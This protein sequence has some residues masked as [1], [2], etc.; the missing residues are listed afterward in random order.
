MILF[1]LLLMPFV[2]GAVAYLITKT[3]ITWKEYVLMTVVSGGVAFGG[4]QLAKWGAMRDTEHWNGRITKKDH[5]TESCC[6]CQTV[7]DAHDSD[8]NCTSSHTEC[9]HFQDYW[10]SAH[11]NTG[12]TLND[13][14]NG[15][16]TTPEWWE[17]A[18]VGEPAAIEHGY[19]NYL[20][21]D[22]D[23]LMTPAAEQYIDQVPNRP[24]VTGRYH[25][26]RVIAHQSSS[27]G[28]PTTWQKELDEMNADLGNK[29]QVDV[30]LLVTKVRDPTFAEAVKAKWLY[31]PKNAVTVV[32]GVPDGQTIEWA[33]VVTLSNVEVLKIEL[34]DE[35]PGRSLDDPEILPFIRKEI[36][37][38]YT[39]TPM[40]EYEYLAS[41]VKPPFWMTVGLYFG[42]LIIIIGLAF[43]MHREDVFGDEGRQSGRGLFRR[44]RRW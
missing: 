37:T 29:Y 7:C 40:A 27:V 3:T 28:V 36:E 30:L 11:V 39:R 20:K 24:K 41:A 2:V 33:R 12:D 17:K 19:T 8:G 42:N 35:L 9:D 1:G 31:G 32:L 14:C 44:R 22:P 15:W 34:R 10:W 16:N 43:W 4:Y 26:R 5:G 25:V 6:H 18:Y 38:Q 23:S 21:A 13:G